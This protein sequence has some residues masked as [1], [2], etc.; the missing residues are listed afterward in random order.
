MATKPKPRPAVSGRK[1]PAA[2]PVDPADPRA[3]ETIRVRATQMGYYEHVRRRTGDV[4]TLIPRKGTFTELVLDKDDEPKLNKQGFA[5][6]C[7]VDDKVL[8]A[9]EQFSPAWMEKVDPRT[10]ERTT[11]PQQDLREQHDAIVQSKKNALE[12]TPTG[13]ANPLE[14]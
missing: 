13:E 3:T 2:D 12:E 10:P 4:F 8:T 1:A 11:G 6:T 14:G 7:E 5:L 9:E